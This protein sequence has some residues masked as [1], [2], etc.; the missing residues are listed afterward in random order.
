MTRQDKVLVL[1]GGVSAEREV[2]C[3]TAA[4]CVQALQD[5][6]LEY[7]CYDFTGDVADFI[8]TL[9]DGY[10]VI[11]N[12]LH[13]TYGEDGRIQAVGDLMK[14]PYSHSGVLASALA[15]DK[16]MSLKLFR[17]QGLSTA[18]S[19]CLDHSAICTAS[20]WPLPLPLVVKPVAEGSSIGIQIYHEGAFSQAQREI[21]K[22]AER[23]ALLFEEYVPGLELTV[24][25]V[26]D[27]NRIQPLGVTELM[28]SESFYDYQAKYS[29]TAGARHVC[30]A[31]I[32]E[33][34]AQDLI[35]A[36]CTAH[37]ALGLRGVSRSDF[38]YDPKQNRWAIL[39]IN[40]QPGMT[41]TSLLPEQAAHFG[42]SFPVLI[43]K[44]LAAAA[45]D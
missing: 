44:I 32:P 4:A 10:T 12:A 43:T 17:Q 30:P 40:T 13:G 39:E 42:W 2:S 28:T 41:P 26:E 23:G 33:T 7:G 9:S 11:L 25:V 16:S 18:A 45:H 21:L 22:Q 15:M 8:A 34:L 27:Q 24:S 36:A 38:R 29:M 31:D 6:G 3:A 20:D 19:V 14:I 35:H 5:L 37:E 1:M